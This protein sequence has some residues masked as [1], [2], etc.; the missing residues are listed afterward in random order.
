MAENRFHVSGGH[1]TKSGSAFKGRCY[2]QV[3]QQFKGMQL[4]RYRRRIGLLILG[5]FLEILAV[6]QYYN[7]ALLQCS[8]ATV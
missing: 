4:R 1:T 3:R 5:E 8:V 2:F 6:Q 7:N